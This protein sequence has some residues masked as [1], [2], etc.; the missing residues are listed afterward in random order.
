MW[1]ALRFLAAPSISLLQPC[2]RLPGQLPVHVAAMYR[3]VDTSLADATGLASAAR[4]R[5]TLAG[6]CAGCMRLHA[7][8][9]L[10]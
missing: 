2:C 5:V 9:T 3:R 4:V 7:C 8:P 1:S 6:C 10:V